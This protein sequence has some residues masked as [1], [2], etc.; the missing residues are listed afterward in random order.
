[1]LTDVFGADE[2]GSEAARLS[3]GSSCGIR[4]CGCGVIGNDGGMCDCE[5]EGDEGGL[6]N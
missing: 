2:G 6:F 4:D 3:M 5:E 1:M